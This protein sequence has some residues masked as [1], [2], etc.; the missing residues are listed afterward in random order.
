MK[1]SEINTLNRRELLKV[2][3]TAGGALATTAFLPSQWNKPAVEVGALPDHALLTPSKWEDVDCH[4]F[5]KEN[6]SYVEIDSII[7]G[8]RTLRACVEIEPNWPDIQMNIIVSIAGG[9]DVIVDWYG[10]TDDAGEA[11]TG[12]FTRT[13]S[14][15]E[16]VYVRGV[17]V[18]TPYDCGTQYPVDD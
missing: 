6:S 18:G 4:L 10:K 3:A 2:L 8:Q 7:A 5:V 14:S 16:D 13:Y 12:D 17:I 9:G 15:D 11:C 1:Q